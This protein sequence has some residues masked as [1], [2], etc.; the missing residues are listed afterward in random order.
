M[1]NVVSGCELFV[2]ALKMIARSAP[3]VAATMARCFVSD[4]SLTDEYCFIVFVRRFVQMAPPSYFGEIT[5]ELL[6]SIQDVPAKAES[7]K[8]Y[9]RNRKTTHRMLKWFEHDLERIAQAKAEAASKNDSARLRR[10]DFCEDFL[11]RLYVS[12]YES[13][14][15]ESRGEPR[16]RLT[17]V[18]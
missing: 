11:M 9:W 16:R 4:P 14:R 18:R 13:E 3:M 1:M 10:L 7:A 2:D 17:P 12:A 8:T 5:L 6:Q 15:T